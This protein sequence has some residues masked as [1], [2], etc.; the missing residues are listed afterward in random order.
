MKVRGDRGFSVSG[1]GLGYAPRG[2][3]RGRGPL[4]NM[5]TS[6]HLRLLSF[7]WHTLCVALIL[8][9]LGLVFVQAMDLADARFDRSDVS[10]ANHL[11]K[12]LVS[13]PCLVV[14][15]LVRPR[16]LRRNAYALY[17][18]TLLLLALVPLI[19]Q[20]RNNA[21]RWIQ[22]PLGFDLQPSELVKLGLI[23]ALAR[24]LYRARL[25]DARQVL[26]PIALTLVP[27]L[28]VVL[29]PDLGTALT[30][31]PI[32]GGM[33][34]LA[35]M[36]G[37]R[38]LGFVG[39]GFA[40]GALVWQLELARGYQLQR[41]D[42]WVAAW[43]PHSLI[44]GRNGHAF[45]AYHSRLGIGNGWWLGTGLGRGVANEAGHLPERD[46]DSIFAVVCEEAG[47]VGT[48]GVLALYAL[49]IVLLLLRASSIRE[50]FTRLVV[51]GVALYFGA[52][53]FINTSVNLGLL[54][55]TGLTLPLL[56]TGGSSLLATATALG[57]ALGLAAH[58][59]PSLDQDAFRA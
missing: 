11:R 41:I 45:H 33:L 42:T 50:R 59:E 12:V 31:P 26:L 3:G 32:A 35:G 53:F 44:E 1:G 15:M 16:W 34:Y 6:S 55:M 19:G 40:L 47:F 2:G 46:S 5:L 54:P 37:R 25:K 58:R 43:D 22:M 36:P 7:D 21:Q 48:L 27:M 9:G 13:L 4:G 28:M 24:A 30:L 49:L 10:F 8:L 18:L 29:Q 14:G 56:S 23:L 39:L 57:L 17:G 52:H 20:E 51:G 38:L